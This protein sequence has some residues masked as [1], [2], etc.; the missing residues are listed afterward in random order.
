MFSGLILTRLR[1]PIGKMTVMEQRYEGEY[2]FVNSRLITNRSVR[3]APLLSTVPPLFCFFGQIVVHVLFPLWKQKVECFVSNSE[4]IAF[5][6]GN[7]REKQ[8]IHSTFQKLVR[9]F[10]TFNVSVAVVDLLWCQTRPI[11]RWIYNVLRYI[12][13]LLPLGGSFTQ[14]HCLPLFNGFR[15]QHHC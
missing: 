14:F 1:R 9:G 7:L 12:L 6:N 15:G 11:L 2:R 13:P 4:E 8:T 3:R 10:R 5:Y